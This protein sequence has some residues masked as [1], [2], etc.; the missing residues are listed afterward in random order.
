MIKDRIL[1]VDDEPKLVHLV[2]E[3]LSA[4]G[5]DVLAAFSGENAIEMVAMEK[6]DLVLLDIVLSGPNDG[7]EIASRI[8]QF[9]DIPIIMLTARVREADLL[10]GF[11]SGADDYITKP[12]SSKELL[13]RIRAVLKRSRGETS[14]HPESILQCGELLIDQARRRVTVR[15]KDVQL[16]PTEYALLHELALHP[17][18]VILHE[19]LL[20][21]VWGSE[22]RNDLEY[23]RAYIR[24]L[25]VK[26][27][28]DPSHPTM[29]L[30]CQGVGYMLSCNE[31]EQG[32]CGSE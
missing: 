5:F 8:R 28:T 30:R 32:D 16:T 17:N 25:R 20:T 10:K 13:V 4:A 18:H 31:D 22:Y 14:A 6:P 24:Y 26:L 29:I 21:A 27:E 23:L 15:G 2:R 19:Q 1:I 11:D 3:V 9:T 12:F 7:F